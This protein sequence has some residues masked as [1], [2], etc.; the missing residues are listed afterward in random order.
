MSDFV[1]KVSS[2]IDKLS[3]EQIMRV[4]SHQENQL[5]LRDDILSNVLDGYA[6]M[7]S[8]FKLLYVNSFLAEL[9][10]FDINAFSSNNTKLQDIVFD[11]DVIKYFEHS[12]SSKKES[13]DISFS[14]N[15]SI[16][17]ELKIH[18]Q[19]VFLKKKNLY[20]LTFKDITLIEK[21]RIEFQKNEGL[22]SMTTMAAGIAHEIKNPLASMSIYL[23]LLNK[24]LDK[25]G[26]ITKE[27]A[28]KSLS[29][30]GDEIERLNSMAVDFLF[31]VKPMKVDQKIKNI[32]SVV[33]KTVSLIKAEVED[34]N[35]ALEVDLK[36]G[37]P[38]VAIDEN[39]I[40]QCLL[41]LIRNAIQAFDSK[42][43]DKKIV[44]STYQDG[45]EIY[46]AVSDNGCG[47][48][49]TQLTRI[50][51]PYYTT[52]A[53]GTGLGLTTIFKIVKEHAGEI[54]VNSHPGTGSEFTIKLP[55]PPSERF[56][57]N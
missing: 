34:S 41:N 36:S 48:T 8:N 56:R 4:M 37:I 27:E 43:F 51:E 20:L 30:I 29:I 11:E 26:S 3:D 24:K 19:T 1:K 15:H 10:Q 16:L 57:I 6:L 49:D 13:F 52:K 39:L 32:N 25:D 31:A 42:S 55:V 18:I 33:E 46:L 12:I 45:N 50:F 44:I 9:L 38:S 7:K 35:I 28:Q 22:A 40:E 5:E 21:F 53:N 54:N 2:K 14:Q 47:M 23:Q 17:G